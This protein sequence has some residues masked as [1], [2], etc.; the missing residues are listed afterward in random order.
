MTMQDQ[1][2]GRIPLMPLADATRHALV[3][4][5]LLTLVYVLG[6]LSAAYVL[7]QPAPVRVVCRVHRHF[8]QVTRVHDFTMPTHDCLPA[9]VAKCGHGECELTHG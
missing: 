5:L 1:G 2:G 9:P 3:L 7:A 6:C 8:P 4:L